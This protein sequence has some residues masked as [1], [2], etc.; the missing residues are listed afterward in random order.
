MY[1]KTRALI[2]KNQTTGGQ[3]TYITTYSANLGKITYLVKGLNKNE[4]KL[5]AAL[6][7]FS[8]SEIIATTSR[9]KLVITRATLIKNLYPQKSFEAEALVFYMAD[10]VDRFIEDGVWDRQ[11][12]LLLLTLLNLL[13]EKNINQ[14]LFALILNYFSIR[15]IDRLGYLPELTSCAHCSNKI[16]PSKLYYLSNKKN[17]LLCPTCRRLDTKSLIINKQELNFIR[18]V[19]RHNFS[20][21]KKTTLENN[22]LSVLAKFFSLY[23]FYISGN[24]PKSYSF[25]KSAYCLC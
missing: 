17:G 19:L 23:I 24:I 15:L 9:G 18:Q 12:L 22:R 21:I 7:P 14:R 20:L 5:K 13:R 11:I 25:I 1:I 4:A 2:L 16:A 6:L 8:Y 3:K 10:A